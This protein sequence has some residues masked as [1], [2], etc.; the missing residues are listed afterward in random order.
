MQEPTAQTVLGRFSGS[1]TEAGVT[2]TFS[3]KDGSYQVR[4]GGHDYRVR[5]VF[6]VEPLQQYLV[7]TE[8]GRL[9][10]LSVAWDVRKQAWYHLYPG[11]GLQAGDP[12]HWTGRG[13]NW[14]HM[15]ADC[16][17]TDV[18]KNYAQG[19]YRT[20]F[21]EISVG[22]EACHGPGSQHAAAG[23]GPLPV[24]L[25]PPASHKFVPD[26]KT[27]RPQPVDPTFA[28][29]EAQVCA[30]CHSRRHQFRAGWTPDQPFLDAYLPA[31]LDE[32]LY[33]VD[34]QQKG[35]VYTYGSF[36][37]SKMYRS[38]VACTDCHEPH[39]T[40]L[41]A[42]GDNL[43]LRCHTAPSH[44]HHEKVTCVDCHAPATTY[45]GIDGR[46]DHSFR[47]PR[48]DLSRQL[49]TP[50]ACNQCHR[51]KDV[52]AAFKR[53]YPQAARPHFGATLAAGRKGDPGAQAPLR[54]LAEDAHQPVI[55][56]ASAIALL[57]DPRPLLADP[58]PWIRR[59]AVAALP[60][61]DP[62]RRSLRDDEVQ[63]VRM[64]A[65]RG[66]PDEDTAALREYVEAQRYNAD[67]PESHLNLG[68]LQSS[69]DQAEA[70]YREAL[71]LDPTFV[72][73]Y[74]NLADLM[75]ATDRDDRTEGILR[76]G[77]RRAHP[78]Q[79]APLLYSLG[80]LQL[81][82]RR[83]PEATRSLG[84]ALGKAPGDAAIGL[85]YALS[86]EATGRVPKAVQVLT[87][88]LKAH[89]YDTDARVTLQRLK[90]RAR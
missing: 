46:H 83:L 57:E 17:S 14:N 22:C 40:K 23:L 67:Q 64:E 4:T 31:G 3:Q 8:E 49:G 66:L 21:S 11:Q 47:I 70:A 65:A 71:K 10:A 36:V 13:Q 62:A 59:A 77:L 48:P 78:D 89:P 53:W 38:G 37:Q 25:T 86:L 55:A 16:H 72:Q 27:N 51:D 60:D 56:R 24:D 26:A 9:Q 32:D 58:D 82:T 2:T 6:G 84:Q 30:R 15:C 20:T 42:Q 19:R 88:V 69:P 85:A 52:E 81:R 28:R 74:A 80:L 1:F 29:Q 12:L 44:S 63:G 41:R 39:S 45:M 87:R 76:E 61:G 34:G 68:L 5:Y 73:G 35:E 54:Q 43:C 7:E 90:A 18:H 50:N 33:Y 79:Q 75:R